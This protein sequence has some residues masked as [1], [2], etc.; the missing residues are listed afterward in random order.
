MSNKDRITNLY[1]HLE[2]IHEQKLGEDWES[3]IL[4]GDLENKILEEIRRLHQLQSVL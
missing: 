3:K 2:K 1:S 4:L